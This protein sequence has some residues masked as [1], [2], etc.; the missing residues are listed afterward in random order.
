MSLKTLKNTTFENIEDSNG[1]FSQ[2]FHETFT[3]GL[4]HDGLFKSIKTQQSELSYQYSTRVI[5]PYEIHY[6]NSSSWKYTNF[7]PSIELMSELYEQIYHEKKIP[8]FNHHIIEDIQLYQ[9]LLSF[10]QSAYSYENTMQTQSK[11]IDALSYLIQYYTFQSKPLNYYYDEKQ[12]IQP[13]LDF[14][15]DCLEEPISLDM[16]AQNAHLSKFYF[17]RLFKK[18]TGLTPHQ[19]IITQRIYKAKALILQGKSLLESALD[20]GFNDQ[21]H[22]IRSFK[23][24]YGY[25]PKTL[26]KKSNFILY[27]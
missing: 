7:Y 23:K 13:S 26:L 22:F 9:R 27:K 3:I 8:L 17:L 6:G 16:L 15:H 20:S 24:I 11:L 21:S 12:S 4:T 5:N 10:F 18:Q 25:S 14:I 19:Y 2:H 1:N